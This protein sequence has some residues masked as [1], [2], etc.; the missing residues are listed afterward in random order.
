[1]DVGGGGIPMQDPY[2]GNSKSLGNHSS[3]AFTT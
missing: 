3:G 1:M 2:L